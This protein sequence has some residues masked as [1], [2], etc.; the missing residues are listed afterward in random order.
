MKMLRR[1]VLKGIGGVTVGLPFLEGL[2]PRKALA[3]GEIVPPYAIFFRQANGVA[4][5]QDTDLGAEPERFWPTTEGPLTAA[6]VAGR[7]M[8]ELSAHLDRLL[9]VGGVNMQDFNYGDGHARG[10]LQLLTAQGPTVEGVGGDSEAA[11]ESID[12]RIGRELNTGGRDSLFLYAGMDGWLGGPCLSYRD[13]AQRR[14]AI[15]DPRQAY[16][17]MMGIDESQFESLAARQKSVNDLVRGQMQALQARP[18]LSASDKARL[19]LHFTSIRDL[20]NSLSCNLTADEQAMLD[21]MS[22]GYES[23]DGDAVL[24]AIRAHMQIAALA[25]AC[26]YTRSVAIQVSS[27]NDG[28]TRY[29]NLESGDLMENY[30]FL[31]HRR[32]SHDSSGGIIANADLLH[33]Y[34]DVQF[35]QTFA[36]LLDHLAQYDLPDGSNLLDC[37]VS[38]WCNDNGNGPGHSNRNIPFVI[39]GSAA[40]FLR[41]GE[42]IRLPEET[43]HARMLNTIGSAAGLRKTDGSFIDDFGDPGLPRGVL[44]ELLA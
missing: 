36:Y 15:R 9:V 4:C 7:A 10:A 1:N 29:R 33:H 42:Y 30:H 14:A 37:G 16:M 24:N 2:A 11:G 23:D 21:G 12:N 3:A 43:N 34:V 19:D 28:S 5:A 39:A 25:V 6:T 40:G 13:A 26:G 35:A 27:G 44:D 8:E 20:E 22:P 17:G 32:A 31:S 38:V 18:E 41:Q